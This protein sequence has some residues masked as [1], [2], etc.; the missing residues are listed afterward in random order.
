MRKLEL[1]ELHLLID[2][3]KQFIKEKYIMYLNYKI[4]EEAISKNQIFG[5]FENEK[6][7]G[8]VW[9]I[10]LVRKPFCKIEEICSISKGGYKLLK[11]AELHSKHE[12]IRLSVVDFNSK[13]ISFYERNNFLQVGKREGKITNIIM[14]KNIY[15]SRNL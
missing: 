7:T 8:Y 13:A 15:E 5:D 14:D 3:R 6:L 11:F 12:I 10:N 4:L 1:I 2:F 9:F